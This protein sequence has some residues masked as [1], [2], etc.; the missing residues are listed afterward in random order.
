MKKMLGIFI[1]IMCVFIAF[2][3]LEKKINT[4]QNVNQKINENQEI[5]ENSLT[6]DELVGLVNNGQDILVYFYQPNCIYCQQAK[7]IIS[8]LVNE[9]DIDL[10]VF[11]LQKY[12]NGWGEFNVEG[13]PTLIHF[14]GKEEISRLDYLGSEVE[15]REWFEH[16][17]I[18]KQQGMK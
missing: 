3:I 6:L 14:K 18:S 15:Y 5:N 17:L 1:V 8:S 7:P 9:M 4:E 11:N 12:K 13:T 16:E 2:I 10:K